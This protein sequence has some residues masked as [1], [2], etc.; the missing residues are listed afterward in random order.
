MDKQLIADYLRGD[1]E[2]LEVLIKKYLGSIYGFL[3]KYTGN[4][5]DAE[6]LTQETFVKIWKNLKKY[7]AGKSFKGWAFTIAKNTALDYLKKQK[8]IPFAGFETEEGVNLLAEVMADRAAL[9]P[10]LLDQMSFS[11]MLS[12]AIAKLSPKYRAVVMLK[13]E[14]M[15]FQEISGKLK[16]SVNTVKSRHRRA[17]VELRKTIS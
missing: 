4:A 12:L 2:S 11:E 13:L 10:E 9:P 16:E 15:T 14:G 17:L 1:A 5:K 8:A 3:Y 6:D 7:D